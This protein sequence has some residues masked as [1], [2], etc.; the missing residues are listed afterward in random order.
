MG[1]ANFLKRVE[2]ILDKLASNENFGVTQLADELCLSR[3]QLHRKIHAQTGKSASQLIKEHRLSHAQ[4]LL[5]STELTIAEIAY[6]VGFK[7]PAYFNSCYKDRFGC[8]PGEARSSAQDDTP[9]IN[10]EPKRYSK[11]ILLGIATFLVLILVSA[12]YFSGST[13]RQLEDENPKTEAEVAYVKGQHL[14]YQ[15]T[16]ESFQKAAA[17]YYKSLAADTNYTP[18]Y[19][20]LAEINYYSCYPRISKENSLKAEKH[21]RQALAI[22]SDYSEAHRILGMIYYQC[23][24]HWEAASEQFQLSLKND[25]NNCMAQFYFS[26]FQTF[27]T[28]DLQAARSL[29]ENAKAECPIFI[30]HYLLSAEQ[31]IA[32]G[33][34]ENALSELASAKEIDK[35]EASSYWYE[36]V[37]FYKQNKIDSTLRALASYCEKVGL[38]IEIKPMSTNLTE[39]LKR[40]YQLIIDE[41]VSKQGEWADAYFIAK[42]Y[43]LLED[44]NQTMTWLNKAYDQK[45]LDLSKIKYDFHFEF[46]H[47]NPEFLQLLGRMNLGN[48]E[49]VL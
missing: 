43:A 16:P 24:W 20:G 49:S 22:D 32:L 48:Y 11:S 19:I 31:Y 30:Y 2:A 38:P 7:S 25:P 47:D 35:N 45:L 10:L 42:A 17:Y 4:K 39:R 36:S 18:S 8:T 1:E 27:V 13:Y 15:F 34:Y 3:S 33:E 23:D 9:I 29:I 37:V 41:I 12:F 6:Q 28:G 21:A 46:L 44:E 5:V 26:H 14:M 40:S